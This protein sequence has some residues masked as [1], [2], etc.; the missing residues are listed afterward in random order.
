MRGDP[1]SDREV[2]VTLPKYRCLKGNYFCFFRRQKIILMKPGIPEP[3]DSVGEEEY[4]KLI[5][6]LEER[7][8]WC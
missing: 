7:R 3:G 4:E 1:E 8:A 2:L 6:L 5:K